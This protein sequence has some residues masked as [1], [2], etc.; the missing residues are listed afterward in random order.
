MVVTKMGDWD[1]LYEMKD[2]GYREA[3]TQ[4]A[5]VSDAARHGNGFTLKK[6]GKSNMKN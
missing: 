4:D 1:F 2:V 5:R 6:K 3:E